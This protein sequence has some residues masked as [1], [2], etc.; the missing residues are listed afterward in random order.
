M[1][2]TMKEKI[3]AVLNEHNIKTNVFSKVVNGG[4][5]SLILLLVVLT[6]LEV[7]PKFQNYRIVF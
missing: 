1:L 7:D 3:A 2:I 4:I 6:I 5:I